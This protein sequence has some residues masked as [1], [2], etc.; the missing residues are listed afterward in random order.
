MS[1]KKHNVATFMQHYG[2]SLGKESACR[3]NSHMDGQC[4]FTKGIKII[5]QG[6]KSLF[7]QTGQNKWMSTCISSH[8]KKLAQ[9]GPKMQM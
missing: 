5:Q 2:G 6:E 8:T 9:D 3:F 4:L 7:K 1:D